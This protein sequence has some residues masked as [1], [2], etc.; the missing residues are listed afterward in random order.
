MA[1]NDPNRLAGDLDSENTGGVLSGLL[2]DEEEFD[3]RSLWRLGSWGVASVGAVI[4]ALLASQFSIGVR[5]DQVAAAD[6]VRQSQ[7]IQTIAKESQNEARR[8]A[9]AI[10]TLNGDRDRLYSRVT[11]LE[12]GLDSV[13][14][15]ITRQG[16]S[17]AAPTAPWPSAANE[18]APVLQ[19]PPPPVI[20]PV[21]TTAAATVEKPR[22]EAVV[23]EKAPETVASVATSNA[24]MAPPAPLMESKS[25]MAPPDAAATK[26]IEPQKPDKVFTAAPM[27]QVVASAPSADEAAPEI[28]EAA[29]ARVLR[30]EFGV[31]V[32]G[33][34]SVGGLR[35]LWRG[36]LKS[37]S[38]AALTMLRP[39]MVIRETSNG[40][41][42][43][44]RL[45]AGPLADAA[46]AAKICAGLAEND[47]PCET[48]VYDGQRLAMKA[49]D[50]PAAASK[51]SATSPDA[52][53]PVSHRRSSS[54]RA[55][56]ETAAKKTDST[57]TFSSLFGRR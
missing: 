6:L 14:G 22:A 3:R 32:G 17:A 18:T 43:Q 44:L 4:V 25:I 5:R 8:L 16:A 52:A 48:T 57:S 37:R 20:S 39:I 46:A 15:A 11:V 38:N 53:K 24:A 9:S 31:D 12:Q 21:A 51:P 45:V 49:D 56:V 54:K 28:S 36:L 26:L 29:A 10:D 7:Q 55:A 41:G 42:M 33:A 50:A 13:T 27:P 23:T 1:K 30:T 47:R 35:V 34:N 2:A 40:L 19:G